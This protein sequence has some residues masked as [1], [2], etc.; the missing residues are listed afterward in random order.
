VRDNVTQEARRS[1]LAT[2]ASSERMHAK[3]AG[4]GADLVFLDLEDAVAPGAKAAARAKAVTALTSLGWGRTAR[5]I[6]INALDTQW[7]Y[8]DIVDVV[9]GARE[10]LDVIIVPKV[11]RPREVWWVS[12]LLDHLERDLG[13]SKR[14]GL[15]VLIEE[16]QAVVNC[17]KIAR[18]SGRLK[19]IIFGVGDF[20]ASQHARVDANFDPITPYPGDIWHAAR[21]AVVVAARAA[22]IAAID[23]PFPRYR[24]PEGYR[25]SCRQAAVMGYDGKWAIHPGQVPIANDE[26]APTPDQIKAARATLARY[27]TAENAGAGALGEDGTLIDAAHRRHAE[28]TRAMAVALGLWE[29]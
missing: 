3:A 17:A 4:S 6:R 15:E 11:R 12:H 19:A 26:F 5:A 20:S 8:R 23:A 24:D 16:A 25:A 13:L 29:E 7:A 9:S 2:P 10:A 27:R 1:E 14:I 28:S 18:A 21:C 22:G